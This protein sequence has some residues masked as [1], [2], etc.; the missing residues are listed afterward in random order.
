M[1]RSKGQGRPTAAD[2]SL[3]RKVTEAVKPLKGRAQ[4]MEPVPPRV[5]AASSPSGKAASAPPAVARPARSTASRLEP[6][7]AGRLAG[8]DRRTGD[9]LR[10]GRMEI[11]ASLDLHGLTQDRAHTRLRRFLFQAD[12]Q[13]RRCLLVVTGKGR[14]GPGVLRR[15]VPLW[16]ND[17]ELRPLILAVTPAQPHH[18]GEGALYVLL[19][20][21]RKP[22][23]V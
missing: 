3:W 20:R 22:E 5:P 10:R 4:P 17:S 8:I 18:G 19:R 12:A 13:G 2:L 15:A 14:T 7:E 21:R 6:L 1:A 16:L 9:R 11:E 23:A